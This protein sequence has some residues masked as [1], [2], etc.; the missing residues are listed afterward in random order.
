[1]ESLIIIF[2]IAILFFLTFKKKIES[3]YPLLPHYSIRGD[4]I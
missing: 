4:I 1:M 3:F 2:A